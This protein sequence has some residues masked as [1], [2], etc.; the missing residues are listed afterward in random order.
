MVPPPPTCAVI[1]TPQAAHSTSMSELAR[2]RV[3]PPAPRMSREMI[4]RQE[5]GAE[6]GDRQIFGAAEGR[7]AENQ[8]VPVFCTRSEVEGLV[9]RRLALAASLIATTL[10]APNALGQKRPPAAPP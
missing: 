7:R 8:P 3:L 6:N 10:F 4:G 5:N 9:L 2:S 1:T